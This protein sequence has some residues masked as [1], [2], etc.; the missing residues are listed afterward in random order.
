VNGLEIKGDTLIVSVDLDLEM[1][2]PFSRACQKLLEVDEKRLYLDLSRCGFVGSALFG[3]MF[4]LNYRAK[5]ED[6][7]LVLRVHEHLLSILELLGLPQ[8]MEVEVV[9]IPKD[10]EKTVG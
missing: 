10:D 6:R 1:Q 7:E 9:D 3:Q 5:K 2:E 8:L 4:H